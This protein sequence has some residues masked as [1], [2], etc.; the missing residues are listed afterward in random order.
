LEL[1]NWAITIRWDAVSQLAQPIYIFG[2]ITKK[3][4]TMGLQGS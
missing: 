2:T 4:A 3:K 1:Y